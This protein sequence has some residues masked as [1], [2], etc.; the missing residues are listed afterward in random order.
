[1]PE[2]AILTKFI[3]SNFKAGQI[4][5]LIARLND[6]VGETKDMSRFE[7]AASK[8]DC[9]LLNQST[10]QCSVYAA[11]PLTC[12]GMHSLDRA[13]CEADD[14]TPGQNHPI[15]QYQSHKA[16]IQSVAIGLQLGLADN[17]IVPKELELASALLL[18]LT[19]PEAIEDWIKDQT[20]FDTAL[21][22]EE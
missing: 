14:A 22:P 2:L 17:D 20:E 8:I 12:R 16:I 6:V 7:R 9:P 13:A 15:P 5:T 3:K 21:V 1:M 10:R 11:R 19:G 4:V 18:A